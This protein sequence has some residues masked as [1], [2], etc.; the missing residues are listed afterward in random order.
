MGFLVSYRPGGNAVP[1]GEANLHGRVGDGYAGG[2]AGDGLVGDALGR[3]RA[4]V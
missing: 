1:D 4:S 2:I 3:L